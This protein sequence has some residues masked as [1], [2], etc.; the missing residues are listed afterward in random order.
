[1][2]DNIDMDSTIAESVNGILLMKLQKF[3]IT[4]GILS[5]D[6]LCI[7]VGDPVIKKGGVSLYYFMNL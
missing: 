5:F 6:Y 2:N 3:A 1:M 4:R 7:A